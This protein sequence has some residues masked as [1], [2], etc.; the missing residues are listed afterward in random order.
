MKTNQILESTID[1]TIIN[2]DLSILNFW[3]VYFKRHKDFLNK[4]ERLAFL[5]RYLNLLYEF[6]DLNA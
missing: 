1:R 5:R 2:N 6:K 3:M 4:R